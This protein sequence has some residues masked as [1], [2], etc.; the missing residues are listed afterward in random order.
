[1][2]LPH[3]ISSTN[4]KKHLFGLG[5]KTY[6]QNA[7]KPAPMLVVKIVAYHEVMVALVSAGE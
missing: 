5:V 3:N 1:V 2:L 7:P 4:I 6:L